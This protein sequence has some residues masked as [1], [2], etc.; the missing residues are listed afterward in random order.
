[1]RTG[2]VEGVVFRK[3]NN[4]IEY[5]GLKRNAERGSFWQPVTGGIEEG[6]TIMQALDRELDEELSVTDTL[7]IFD[8]NYSFTLTNKDDLFLNETVYGVEVGEN[9]VINISDEHTEYRWGTYEDIRALY[10]WDSTKKSLDLLH[11]Y[12]QSPK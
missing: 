12:L 4:E 8:L 5:L 9:T 1:M 6:E 11:Q 7:R 2:Q 3:V 10:K